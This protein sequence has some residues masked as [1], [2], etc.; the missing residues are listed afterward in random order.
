MME[1]DKLDRGGTER[2]MTSTLLRHYIRGALT[3]AAAASRSANSAEG[4]A[5]W[6]D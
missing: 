2:T 6:R 4:L 3:L 5:I 1:T